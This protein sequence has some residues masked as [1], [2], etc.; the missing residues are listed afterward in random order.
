M[1]EYFGLPVISL[2]LVDPYFYHLDTALFV[3]SSDDR[4]IA[5]YP[6]AFSP[7][8]REVLAPAVPGRGR[9]HPRGR[10]RVRPELGLATATTS[11]STRGA[12]DLA[13]ALARARLQPRPRRPVGVPQ[14]RRRH[15]VLHPGDPLMTAPTH[16]RTHRPRTSAD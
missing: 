15:Q 1:Q 6:E 5:Y 13:A 16:D 4:T 2:E 11:S 7:G 9:R 8:S 3:L 14:G 10:A 12:A